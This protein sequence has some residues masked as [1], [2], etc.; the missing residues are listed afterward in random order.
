MGLM[1][2]GRVRVKE[3]LTHTVKPEGIKEAYGGLLDKKDEYLGVV[4]DWRDA[5]DQ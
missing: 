4:L 5:F 3:L 2:E 1:P